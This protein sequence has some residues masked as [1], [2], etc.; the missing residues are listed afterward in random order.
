MENILFVYA[1]V[2]LNKS[3][4]SFYQPESGMLIGWVRDGGRSVVQSGIYCFHFNI[5]LQHFLVNLDLFLVIFASHQGLVHGLG[6]L[7]VE[8]G[9]VG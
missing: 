9:V 8:Q 3:H 6:K 4:V 5:R 2:S 1:I 7:H